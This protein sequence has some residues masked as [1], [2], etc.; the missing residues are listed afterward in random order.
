MLSL[1]LKL[2]VS[3]GLCCTVKL[4]PAIKNAYNPAFSDLVLP[5]PFHWV[6]N[7]SSFKPLWRYD[8]FVVLI[9]LFNAL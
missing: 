3:F 8:R 2:P 5:L 6:E 4:S 7:F 1:I 9:L